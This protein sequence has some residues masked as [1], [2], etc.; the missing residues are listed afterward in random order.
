MSLRDTPLWHRFLDRY[1]PD[2]THFFYDVAL[3]PGRDPGPR[4]EDHYR[5]AWVRLT[6]LRADALGVQPNAW[7]LFEVRPAATVGALG[8]LYAYTHAWSQDPPDNRAVFGVIVTDHILH[9]LD[10]MARR[11]GFRTIVL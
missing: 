5:H 6:R 8:H 3:G 11:L 7:T 1:G 9:D 10:S 2:Y 4:Y